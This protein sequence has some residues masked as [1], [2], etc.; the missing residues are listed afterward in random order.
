MNKEQLVKV[1]IVDDN[2]EAVKVLKNMLESS[3]SV[4]VV[5]TAGDAETAADAIIKTEP[6]IIF[7]DIEL[8]TMSGLEFCTLIRNDI[9]PETKIV[10]YTGHD[11]YMLEAIRHQATG[12]DQYMLE[13][14]RHQA[15]DYLLKPP[16]EHDLS[17]LMTRY[18]ENKLASIPC[19]TR[20][21][22]RLPIILV[23]N[24]MNEHVALNLSDIA[25]FR[26]NQERKI[27]EIV[28][29]N[30]AVYTLRHRTT[31]N[32]I[33]NYSPDFVQIHKRYIVNINKIKMIQESLC[34]L[35]EPLDDIRE[36]KISKN[37]R[38]GFMAAF[39]SM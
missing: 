12:H 5:G 2:A 29:C 17:L 1:F 38:Q 22:E 32:I 4:T 25:F 13:A 24:A 15:F 7:L 30:N 28:C 11:Q 16:T 26:F 6:D 36:L 31:T 9:K 34:I 27:W 18:Y 37:Y 14:I 35:E 19:L 23:V 39:Y 20:S 10:F 8:P 33:L 3:Y 21:E